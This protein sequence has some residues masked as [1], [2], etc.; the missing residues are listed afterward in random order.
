V[1]P[2]FNTHAFVDIWYKLMVFMVYS[3][4]L[5]LVDNLVIK[6]SEYSANDIIARAFRR[7]SV[8]SILDTRIDRG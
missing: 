6:S 7:V 1:L 4:E 2:N 5:V 3:A 8:P